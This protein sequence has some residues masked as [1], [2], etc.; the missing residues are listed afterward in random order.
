MCAVGHI[1]C[2]VGGEY[3]VGIKHIIITSGA[4]ASLPASSSAPMRR[5]SSAVPSTRS[6]PA[7]PMRIAPGH[8]A[9]RT[10]TLVRPWC[11]C[12][13]VWLVPPNLYIH[14]YI[15]RSSTQSRSLST[16]R[17]AFCVLPKSV[18]LLLYLKTK[19][20]TPDDAP[21]PYA[22]ALYL[23]CF[24]FCGEKWREKRIFSRFKKKKLTE[25]G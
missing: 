9:S 12:T 11:A 24:V 22:Y 1:G 10:S 21:P 7:L 16:A 5:C 18:S 23:A 6:P 4:P 25:T 14:T 20:K 3:P 19:Q 15:R 2:C 13:R 8:P 17:R